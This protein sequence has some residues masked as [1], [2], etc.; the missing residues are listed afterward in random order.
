MNSSPNCQ[1]HFSS[2]LTC[3]QRLMIATTLLET[4]LCAFR[5]TLLREGRVLEHLVHGLNVQ[6]TP[7]QAVLL[8]L[9]NSGEKV[10]QAT[11][12]SVFSWVIQGSQYCYLPHR[13]VS[14]FT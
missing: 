9:V 4:L 7:L 1:V 5:T 10:S 13:V 6:T 14:E 3:L 8:L 2:F 11:C 12:A